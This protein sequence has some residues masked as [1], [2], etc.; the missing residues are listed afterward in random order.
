MRKILLA[1]T[2]S[3]VLLSACGGSNKSLDSKAGDNLSSATGVTGATGES[4]E[5]TAA[6]SPSTAPKIPKPS[7]KVP[8]AIPTSL[9]ITDLT[10]GTGAKAANGDTVVVRYVGVRTKDGKEFDSNYDANEP[11]S[12]ELGAGRVIKGWDQGLVGAQAGGQRQL[13][14]PSELAYGAQSQGDI[15]GANEALTFV[16]D[17]VAVIPAVDAKNE[18]TLVIKPTKAE[19]VLTEDLVE[20]TGTAAKKNDTVVFNYIFYRGDTGAKLYSSWGSTPATIQ[21]LVG[22][23]GDASLD[24]LINGMVGLKVGGRRQV[25]VPAAL[26]FGGKGDSGLGLPAGVDVIMV[27]DLIAIY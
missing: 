6:A 22:Q 21:L 7:V 11:F 13:D 10:V 24:A 16:I 17:V 4:S 25:T 2:A 19:K 5:T 12:V 3:V 18:P 20:G 27:A 23:G 26:A 8:S 14:I 9:V 15:I 1:A